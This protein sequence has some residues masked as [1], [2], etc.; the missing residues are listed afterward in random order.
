MIPALYICALCRSFRLQ[1]DL[2]CVGWGVK[3]YSL[4]RLRSLHCL[5]CNGVTYV[6]R[7]FG[8]LRFLYYPVLFSFPLHVL[9]IIVVFIVC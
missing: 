9:L 7:I 2:Y 6:Y 8:I 1:N 5:N 3:L 4:T